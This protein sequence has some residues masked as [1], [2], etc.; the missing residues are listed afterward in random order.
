MWSV[1]SVVK[2]NGIAA[3]QQDHLPNWIGLLHQFIDHFAGYKLVD[4]HRAFLRLY[5]AERI[6]VD[7]LLVNRIVHELPSELDPFVDRR[8]HI[9]CFVNRTYR[10]HYSLCDFYLRVSCDAWF[11]SR[12]KSPES[13]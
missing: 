7:D 10:V 13:P 3:Q 5:F 11:S 4:L 1:C 9:P 6:L 2:K 12:R 8:L